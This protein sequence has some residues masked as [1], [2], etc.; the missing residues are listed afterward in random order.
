MYREEQCV[1]TADNRSHKTT[2]TQYH[3]TKDAARDKRCSTMIGQRC[4]CDNAS[5]IS[6]KNKKVA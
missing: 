4:P 2:H 3:V 1:A 5:A 6:V